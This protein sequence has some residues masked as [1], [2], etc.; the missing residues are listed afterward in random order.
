MEVGAMEEVVM[1]DM[2]ALGVSSQGLD[3]RLPKEGQEE[4]LEEQELELHCQLEPLLFLRQA[5]QEGLVLERGR[6]LLKC[7]VSVCQD[8]TKVDWYQEKGLVDVE[9]CREWPLAPT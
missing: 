1:E 5:F 2:V 3:R 6:K 8:F 7:Q 4:G 9:F